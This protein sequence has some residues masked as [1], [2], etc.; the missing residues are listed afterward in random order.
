M[1]PILDIVGKFL[2][3]NAGH[4]TLYFILTLCFILQMIVEPHLL[5]RAIEKLPRLNRTV[6]TQ[7]IHREIAYILVTWLVVQACLSAM[8]FMDAV[9]LPKLEAFARAAIIEEIVKAYRRRFRAQHVGE[10]ISKITKLPLILKEMILEF[11][12]HVLPA[13]YV[14]VGVIGYF[15]YTHWLLGLTFLL[16]LVLFVGLVY[17]GVRTCVR[18]ARKA[19]EF[20]DHVYD[21]IGDLLDNLSNVYDSDSTDLEMNRLHRVHERLREKMR[22]ALFSIAWLRLLYNGAYYFYFVVMHAALIYL[23]IH[24][25][26]GIG[27]VTSSVIIVGYVMTAMDDLAREIAPMIWHFSILKKMDRFIRRL[28]KDAVEDPVTHGRIVDGAVEFRN[29]TFGHDAPVLEDV[30]FHVQQGETLLISGPI[31]SG[32][33]TMVQ[34]VMGSQPFRG[35]IYIDGWNIDRIN[36]REIRRAIIHVPQTPRLFDRTLY[37]NVSY[38]TRATRQEV[39]AVMDLFDIDFITLDEKLGR[40]GSRLSGGQRQIV[41]LMRCFMRGDAPLVILDEPTSNMD[42]ATR[43]KAMALLAPM[44]KGRT[45]IMISHDPHLIEFSTRELKIESLKR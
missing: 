1:S 22:R 18:R 8:D 37:E 28:R 19:E 31:G 29:V 45:V 20:Q 23:Y 21:E 41:Y 2:K 34:L 27:A 12:M 17:L 6:G 24:G 43:D 5:G 36:S 25:R 26:L 13:F 7:P 11:R 3:Q 16:C 14:F 42:P 9:F 35:D 33:S 15:F 10:I 40:G 38:G 32:K 39:Q 4:V 30:S 44:M